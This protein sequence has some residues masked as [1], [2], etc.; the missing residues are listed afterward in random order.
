MDMRRSVGQHCNI[1]GALNADRARRT[2]LYRQKSRV[3]TYI[4]VALLILIVGR[5]LICYKSSCDGYKIDMPCPR[6]K[7]GNL[8][9]DNSRKGADK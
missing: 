5:Q 4:Y 3:S 2:L 9:E 7:N 8:T 1:I 6:K